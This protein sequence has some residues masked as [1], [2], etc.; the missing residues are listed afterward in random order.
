MKNLI[1]QISIYFSNYFYHY[2]IKFFYKDISHWE[3][4]KKVVKSIYANEK[5]CRCMLFVAKSFPTT[6]NVTF[7]SD[8]FVRVLWF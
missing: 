5:K 3:I 2:K 1:L 8:V 6:L 4:S 7:V